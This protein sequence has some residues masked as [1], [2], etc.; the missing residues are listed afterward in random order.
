MQVPQII[1]LPQILTG[2]DWNAVMYEG[3]VAFGGPKSA[4]G[5]AI[6]LYFVTLVVLGNCIFSLIEFYY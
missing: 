2:E 3:I 1:S 4:K 6:S 5:L